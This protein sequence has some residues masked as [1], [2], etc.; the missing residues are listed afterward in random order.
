MNSINHCGCLLEHYKNCVGVEEIV[1]YENLPVSTSIVLRVITERLLQI[2]TYLSI[3]CGVG[4]SVFNTLC[5]FCFIIMTR[6]S[7]LIIDTI[8]QITPFPSNYEYNLRT[9]RDEA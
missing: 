8:V 4:F 9:K 5:V 2:M 1:N 6:R 7:E 3:P